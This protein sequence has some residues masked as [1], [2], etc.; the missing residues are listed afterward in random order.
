MLQPGLL[1]V[2]VFVCAATVSG[3]TAAAAYTAFAVPPIKTPHYDTDPTYEVSPGIN[4]DFAVDYVDDWGNLTDWSQ[5]S[6]ILTQHYGPPTFCSIQNRGFWLFGSTFVQELDSGNLNSFSSSISMAKT[7]AHPGWLVDLQRP[8]IPATP[9]ESE[10]DYTYFMNFST[11][12]HTHCAVIGSNKAVQLWD[13]RLD[14]C[15]PPTPF[16]RTSLVVYEFNAEG[17]TLTV[18]RPVT[19]S[20]TSQEYHYGSFATTVVKGRVYLYALDPVSDQD[21]H[22]A[23]APSA[24]I[25]DKSTWSYWDQSLGGWSPTEPLP[26]ARRESAAIM[27]LPN[28]AYYNGGISVFY[29][30][31]HNS[32]LMFFLAKDHISL[33]V[34]YSPTPLG[35][36][37]NNDTLVF[38]FPTYLESALVTPVPFQTGSRIAGQAILITSASFES[39][40]Y[41]TRAWKLKF[42]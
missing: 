4:L 24:T 37:S 16:T 30:A 41:V 2:V 29:S 22:V 21:V 38:T 25:E 23:S 6:T 5:S 39:F 31:Y 34:K 8:P 33:L 40:I 36:W 14:D 12:P 7:F 10:V 42:E 28:L 1:V 17:N 20:F 35:P 27:S 11:L 3:T 32:Y 13:M 15:G 19:I 18:T 9:Y 26:T